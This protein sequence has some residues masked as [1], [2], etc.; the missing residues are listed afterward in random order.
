MHHKVRLDS[1]IN[2]IILS[3][4]LIYIYIHICI[5]ICI[6]MCV[7]LHLYFELKYKVFKMLYVN[8]VQK[9]HYFNLSLYL[10]Y[11]E[12]DVCVFSFIFRIE[13]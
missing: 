5:C 3:L 13:V 2:G 1:F 4:Y 6:C 8:E 10:I 7:F 12:I 11:R 9:Y